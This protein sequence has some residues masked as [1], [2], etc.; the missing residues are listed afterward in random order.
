LYWFGFLDDAVRVVGRH[1]C[2]IDEEN[3]ELERDQAHRGGAVC[4]AGGVRKGP[5]VATGRTYLPE[6]SER[7]YDRARPDNRGNDNFGNL[8]AS[9]FPSERKLAIVSADMHGHEPDET[10]LSCCVLE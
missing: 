9:L 3:G 4:A 1:K 10:F 6:Q 5:N 2:R 8:L 7:R